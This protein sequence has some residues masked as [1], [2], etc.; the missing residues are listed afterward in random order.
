VSVQVKDF[1][2]ALWPTAIRAINIHR[3]LWPTALG[4]IGL[5]SI[6]WRTALKAIAPYKNLKPPALR[7]M[8]LLDSYGPQ[9]SGLYIFIGVYALAAQG[10]KFL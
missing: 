5:Y 8:E 1:N 3:I 2:R 4:A 9:L 6:L 7:A 10:Y